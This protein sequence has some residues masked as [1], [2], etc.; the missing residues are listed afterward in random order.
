MKC[1]I[2]AAGD[3]TRIAEKGNSKPLLSL[4]GLPL[5]E[6]T[7]AT[8]HQAGI[9]DFYVVTGHNADRVEAFLS[10]VGQRRG[11]TITTIRNEDWEKGNATSLLKAR[12][13]LDQHFILLM[14]DHV[15]DEAILSSLIREAPQDGEIILAADFGIENNQLVDLND[16]TRVLAS[17]RR[18]VDIGKGLQDYNAYDTGIFLCSPT[19]FAAVEESLAD[20]DDSLSGGVR[21]LADRRKAKVVDI[22]GRYWIDVDTTADL[23]KAETLLRDSLTKPN[24]G[25]ISRTINRRISTGIVTPLLLKLSRRITAN[26]VSLLSFAVSLVASLCFFLRYPVIG[27][28][29]IQMASILDGSDGEIAR[30]RKLQSPFG[31]FFDAV[32]DR[33]SD[34]FILFGMFYYSLTASGNSALLGPY[35]VPLVLVTSMLA[36]FGTAMVSYTSAKSVADFGYRYG[37]RWT[38]AGK[39]RDLRLF[40]LFVGG[41]AAWIHPVSVLVAISVVAILTNAIV[42]RRISISWGYWQRPHPLIGARLK[43]VIFDFDGTIA[44]T[45]PFLSALAV[46][47]ITTNYEISEEEARGRYRETTGIDFRTQMERIFPNHP[48]NREVVA[49]FEARKLD[50]ILDHPVF[51]EVVPTLML[52]KSRHVARFICSSSTEEIVADYASKTNI[53]DLIDGCFGYRPGLS[54][55]QQIELILRQHRLDPDEVLFVSDSLMDYEFV[56]DKGIRFIGIRRMFEE[57]EFQERGLCSVQDLSALIR[58]WDQSESLVQFV[59]KA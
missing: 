6:R 1:L 45:M 11:L 51:S 9:S 18:L 2:L 59:A 38:A 50:G 20:G 4:A 19:I 8:A 48:R 23:K 47:L 57:R 40:L 25:F 35:W 42:L 32:V 29:F 30:L 46:N 17:D 10:D 16:V 24:D 13:H 37:G 43:A 31:N 58:L 53:A 3:G 7:I 34:S 26:Q 22:E 41:I 39:G 44:D 15:F 49:A 28:L 12:D 56:R 21:R 52:F 54:K 55:G 33:Y 14:G 36:I 5:I 27:G